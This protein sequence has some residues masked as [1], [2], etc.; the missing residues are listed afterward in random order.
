MSANAA[1]IMPATATLNP[2]RGRPIIFSCISIDS[3]SM[4][5]N[6]SEKEAVY[7]C[8]SAIYCSL[9]NVIE[10]GFVLSCSKNE[11]LK[12]SMPS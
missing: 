10:V 9:V 8:I 1:I 5:K 3:D 11:V 2:V 12:N 6:D 4:L 7:F